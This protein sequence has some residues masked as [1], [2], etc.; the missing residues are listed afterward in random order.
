[1]LPAIAKDASGQPQLAI[2]AGIF[3]V[4]KDGTLLGRPTSIDVDV[5]HAREM[6]EALKKIHPEP[7][8]RLLLDQREV[9]RKI[10]VEAR[11]Y[12]AA[13]TPQ[14]DKIAILVGS[15]ASRFLASGILMVSGRTKQVQAFE[16]EPEALV[17]LKASTV[18]PRGDAAPR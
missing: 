3:T 4:R 15:A 13:N 1:M 5:S 18:E 12:L 11:A 10:S 14:F 17:W 2:R 16:S 7:R 9:T 6:A 8:G